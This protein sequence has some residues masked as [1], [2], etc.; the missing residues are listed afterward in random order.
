MVSRLTF[1]QAPLF[2][3]SRVRRAISRELLRAAQMHLIREQRQADQAAIRAADPARYPAPQRKR[4]RKR[5]E[6]PLWQAI[7]KDIERGLPQRTIMEIYAVSEV[8]YHQAV[9]AGEES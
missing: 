6:K 8:E 7:R 2:P 1:E 4:P 3:G 5:H 9:R